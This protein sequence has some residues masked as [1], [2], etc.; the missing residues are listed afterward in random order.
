VLRR[1]PSCCCV[2]RGE[3]V[4]AWRRRCLAAWAERLSPGHISHQ[5]EGGDC[6][7]PMFLATPAL[8]PGRV[9]SMP[10][11]EGVSCLPLKSCASVSSTLPVFYLIWRRRREKAV[12]CMSPSGDSFLCSAFVSLLTMF[13]MEASLLTLKCLLERRRVPLSWRRGRLP[14][15]ER[16]E[17][18]ARGGERRT[19]CQ[20]AILSNSSA[21]A[22]RPA[23]IACLCL[24]EEEAAVCSLGGCAH[25]YGD[26]PGAF[27]L[28]DTLLF[29]A[30]LNK[31]CFLTILGGAFCSWAFSTCLKHSDCA[32]HLLPSVVWEKERRG[33]REEEGGRLLCRRREAGRGSA[34]DLPAVTA[35]LL[36]AVEAVLTLLPAVLGVTLFHSYSPPY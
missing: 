2:P 5:E 19:P 28:E 23:Y 10:G 7:L 21:V 6:L 30:V 27:P 8:S 24:W 32:L 4:P 14:A 15:L 31:T 16:R 22:G 33:K 9:H 3:A 13:L 17:E 20:K 34:T 12:P 26:M 29:P 35:V 18:R 36:P 25:L 1:R 11:M